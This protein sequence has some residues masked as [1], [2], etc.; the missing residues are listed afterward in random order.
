[1]VRISFTDSLWNFSLQNI[2]T[3][4]RRK[5]NVVTA[6]YTISY[7]THQSVVSVSLVVKLVVGETEDWFFSLT[8]TTSRTGGRQEINLFLKRRKEWDD[9]DDDKIAENEKSSVYERVQVTGKEVK[10]KAIS[11]QD[12]RTCSFIMTWKEVVAKLLSF[13]FSGLRQTHLS[14]HVESLRDFLWEEDLDVHL[15]DDDDDGGDDGGDEMITK[16]D[17]MR[18]QLNVSPVPVSC[19]DDSFSV[20][21]SRVIIFARIKCK[22]KTIKTMVL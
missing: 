11:G 9:D 5:R 16:K 12:H 7:A 8:V 2:M 17:T 21:Q 6:S 4:G 1:M 19:T 13:L 15:E 22:G 3:S 14:C 20:R 18:C 10:D